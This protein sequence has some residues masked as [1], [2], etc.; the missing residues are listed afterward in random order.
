MALSLLKHQKEIRMQHRIE[1]TPLS[2]YIK[3]QFK[4]YPSIS[5][6]ERKEETAHELG[7]GIA[8]VYRWLKQGNVFIEIIGPSI[9][10]D[11]A[12]IQVWKLEKGP[13]Q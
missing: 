12:C 3:E 5:E 8:T 7:V 2:D 9:A 13:I 11:D 6:R 4:S 10:G 1:L